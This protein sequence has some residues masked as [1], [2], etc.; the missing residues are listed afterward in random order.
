MKN[1]KWCWLATEV[2]G[3]WRLKLGVGNNEFVVKGLILGQK[4]IIN[5]TGKRGKIVFLHLK[6]TKYPIK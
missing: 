6:N 3:G 5:I 4:D 1:K 2:R